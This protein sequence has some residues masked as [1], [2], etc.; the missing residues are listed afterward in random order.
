MKEHIAKPKDPEGLTPWENVSNSECFFFK[1]EA[2]KNERCFSNLK[3]KVSNRNKGVGYVYLATGRWFS[4][5]ADMVVILAPEW[6]VINA[7]KENR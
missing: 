3:M 1:A 4:E 7:G 5:Y 2:D 6:Q